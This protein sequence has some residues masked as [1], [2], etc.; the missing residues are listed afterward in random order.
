MTL[1]VPSDP[2][3]HH[4]NH[5]LAIKLTLIRTIKNIIA[6]YIAPTSDYRYESVH[7]ASTAQR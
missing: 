5:F 7:K 1:K 6:A 4:H 3:V 2:D